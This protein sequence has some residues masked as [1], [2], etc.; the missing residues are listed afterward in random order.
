MKYKLLLLCLFIFSHSLYS[1]N[2]TISTVEGLPL[3][4]ICS[5]ILQKVYDKA[6]YELEIRSMPP[7]RAT[8]ESTSGR[9]D[10]ETH[11]I[12]SYGES[13]PELIKVPFPIY[14]IEISLFTISD[15][16]ARYATKK[17]FPQY[18]FTILRGIKNSKDLTSSFLHVNE[19]DNAMTMFQLLQM[20]RTDF[21]VMSN[22]YGKAFLEKSKIDGIITHDIPLQ[23]TDMF[24]Y[25]HKD[26]AD[27]VPIIDKTLRDLST[28]GELVQIKLDAEEQVYKVE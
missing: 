12:E 23:V 5:Y 11:R 17:D 8:F 16:P 28:S 24:H 3:S 1:N 6:G 26:H 21:A 27:L 14:S 25:L 13:H 10:G 22:I 7:A 18:R 19:V 2:I 20:G 4:D 9:V 15:N